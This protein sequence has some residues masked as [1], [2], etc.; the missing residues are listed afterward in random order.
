MTGRK[1]KFGAFTLIEMLI[2]VTIMA[3]LL[4]LSVPAV[5]SILR[6][7]RWTASEN[8]VRGAL[9]MARGYAL[10]HQCYA[11]VRF[12]QDNEGRQYLVLIENVEAGNVF[13]AVPNVK[14]TV[15]PSGMGAITLDV[16]NSGFEDDY[17]DADESDQW[18]LR[19]ATTFCIVF[20]PTG[21]L[22]AKEVQIRRRLLEDA[23]FNEIVEVD[24][25]NAILY[26]DGWY[27]GPTA[28]QDWCGVEDSTTGLFLYEQAL[29]DEVDVDSRWAD[30]VSDYGNADDV[31]RVVIN[32]YTGGIIDEADLQ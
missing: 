25:G 1:Q 29:M 12:Q 17:L 3:I 18:C 15:L 30:Y 2:V 13:N 20:S 24:T 26:D 19:G 10:Q 21:Q 32:A 8:T 28:P 9:S 16:E 27:A 22:V 7:H 31:S 14:P 6:S 4:A 5:S 11:G 23:T